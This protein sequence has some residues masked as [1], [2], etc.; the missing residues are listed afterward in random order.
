MASIQRIGSPLTGKVSCRVQIRVKGRPAVPDP[1]A[2]TGERPLSG[3]ITTR[4]S[5]LD[6]CLAQ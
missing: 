1:L 4:L 5:A 2:D 6:E 3:R